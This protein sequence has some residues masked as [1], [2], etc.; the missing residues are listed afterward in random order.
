MRT[1]TP[2]LLSSVS[3]FGRFFKR[4]VS[5]GNFWRGRRNS[6]GR[7]YERLPVHIVAFDNWLCDIQYAGSTLIGWAILICYRFYWFLRGIYF[8]V[9]Y[10]LARYCTMLSLIGSYVL[11][12]HNHTTPYNC[13]QGD[14]G[15][16]YRKGQSSNAYVNGFTEYS[17]QIN[18]G[19]HKCM[20]FCPLRYW[21]YLK[22][23][24]HFVYVSLAPQLNSKNDLI[25]R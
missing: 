20:S 4:V 18:C 19:V 13:Y 7:W 14:S 23:L 15:H 3:C 21:Q 5:N 22:S 12:V 9:P 10:Y 17:R 11:H 8:A 1:M 24:Y 25:L 2:S 16:C 6:R